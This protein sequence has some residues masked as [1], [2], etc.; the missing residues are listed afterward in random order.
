MKQQNQTRKAEKDGKKNW[1]RM[2]KRKVGGRGKKK[3]ISYIRK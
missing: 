3:K 1:V 2:W